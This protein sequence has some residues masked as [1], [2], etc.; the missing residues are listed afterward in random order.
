MA[1]TQDPPSVAT[2]EETVLALK[3]KACAT[4]W[5]TTTFLKVSGP[6]ALS[7]I[8][9]QCTQAI[10]KIEVA[11]GKQGLFLDAKAKIIS[12]CMIWRAANADWVNP[13]NNT[14][15]EDAPCLLLEC[16]TAQADALK[17]HLTKYRLRAKVTIEVTNLA[18]IRVSGPKTKTILEDQDIE[19]FYTEDGAQLD[20]YVVID[21]PDAIHAYI[22]NKLPLLADPDTWEAIRITN[23]RPYLHDYIIGRM[24]AEVGAMEKAVALD[25]GCY[26]GQEP[27]VRLHYRGH[28]NRSLRRIDSDEDFVCPTDTDL[29]EMLTIYSAEEEDPQKVGQLTT[30]AKHPDG[31]HVGFAVLRNSVE[32]GSLL[33]LG[34]TIQH[35]ISTVVT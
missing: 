3:E 26:L 15:T 8:D 30:W 28:A 34:T 17:E 5:Q 27:V 7:F 32:I 22:N 35:S 20:E 24:P 16:P 1:E 9:G 31:R 13:K 18:A 29:D 12:A 6:E 11:S 25:G 19:F 10:P 14:V 23:N 2:A 21:T 33:K 4:W